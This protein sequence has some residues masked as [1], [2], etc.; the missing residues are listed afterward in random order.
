M[1]LEEEFIYANVESIRIEFSLNKPQIKYSTESFIHSLFKDLE[2]N[3]ELDIHSLNYVPENNTDNFVQK[4]LV[5]FK[6][7][8]G[9]NT[10]LCMIS[11]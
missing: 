1:D 3:Q 4:V 2:V 8:D 11:N 9:K 6:C 7:F 10:W 5:H